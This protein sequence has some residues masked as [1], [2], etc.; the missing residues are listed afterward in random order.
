M[1]N[2]L[3]GLE[4]IAL[5]MRQTILAMMHNQLVWGLLL[6]FAGSIIIHLLVTAEEPRHIPQM[7]TRQLPKAF[8]KLAQRDHSGKFLTSYTR[9]GQ[10]YYRARVLLYTVILAFLGVMTIALLRY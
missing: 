7:L 2:F 3:F 10:E 9:F 6:G 8:T 5:S 1:N 4:S